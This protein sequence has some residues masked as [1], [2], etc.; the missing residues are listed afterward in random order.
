M[1]II[2]GKGLRHSHASY[3][4]NEFNA[5]VLT[6]SRRL[7]H[8]SPDITLKYYAHMWNRNDSIL[9]NRMAD[10]IS[11]SPA[12]ENKINFNGNQHIKKNN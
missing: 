11:F 3:L 5:D 12:E 2:Q 7:G 9:A 4:I 10:N 6:V 8:S 1:T